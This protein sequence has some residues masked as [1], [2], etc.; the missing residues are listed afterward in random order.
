MLPTIVFH[1][2][3]DMTVNPVNADQIIAQSKAGANLRT[4]INRG[5]APGGVRYTRLVQANE[6]GTPVLEQWTL[7]G[8]GHAWSGGSLAGSYTEPHGPDAS[9]EMIRFFLQ[10]Q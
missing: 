3:Q 10:Q 1:G 8:A 7:H 2:D 6:N 4:T 5:E 9:R